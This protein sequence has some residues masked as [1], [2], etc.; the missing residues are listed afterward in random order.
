M[1]QIIV[2]NADYKKELTKLIELERIFLLRYFYFLVVLPVISALLTSRFDE[3]KSQVNF[4]F[5]A[6]MSK[7]VLIIF[8]NKFHFFKDEKFYLR[9]VMINNVSV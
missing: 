9:N 3:S 2:D 4:G 1:Q 6:V 8:S 5:R 7:R